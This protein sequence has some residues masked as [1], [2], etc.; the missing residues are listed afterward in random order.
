VQASLLGLDQKG[1]VSQRMVVFP[2]GRKEKKDQNDSVETAKREYVEETSDFGGLARYLDFADFCDGEAPA[3]DDRAEK[4]PG[5]GASASAAS[6]SAACTSGVGRGTPAPPVLARS[7]VGWTGRNLALY[8]APASMVV[9]FCEVP[10]E[11]AARGEEAPA[12]VK[13]RRR[14]SSE[15]D[16]QKPKPSASYHVGKTN[17]VRPEWIDAAQLRDVAASTERAPELRL[18]G[19]ECRF[20]PTN[21]SVLRLPEARAWLGLPA[22]P[23][24]LAAAPPPP[25]APPA[26]G[27]ARRAEGQEPV[28]EET[29]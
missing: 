4:G 23:A 16:A 21:A 13:R 6:G 7:C 15:E 11:A 28:G 1:K 22:C 8:F 14:Q 17:H 26:A 20:F 9:L 5:P 27:S 24:T 2:Q 10:A 25:G 3:A 18:D 12:A 29:P 19:E